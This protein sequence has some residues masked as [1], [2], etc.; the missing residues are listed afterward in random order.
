MSRR[1]VVAGGGVVLGWHKSPAGCQAD[2]KMREPAATNRLAA[3]RPVLTRRRR[4]ADDTPD[5]V[6]HTPAAACFESINRAGR[7]PV[8][9]I[10]PCQSVRSALFIARLF[11]IS[12]SPAHF[13]VESVESAAVVA[14]WSSFERRNR[15]EPPRANRTDSARYVGRVCVVGPGERLQLAVAASSKAAGA[16]RVASQQSQQAAVL[17]AAAETGN[18][19]DGR[20]VQAG[21]SSPHFTRHRPA[22]VEERFWFNVCKLRNLRGTSGNRLLFQT[23]S[24]VCVT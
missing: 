24:S 4:Q 13:R 7:A 10:S 6:S 11:A 12:R 16:Q 20:P 22:D 3:W 14:Q 5:S 23:N 19:S 8:R 2:I 17:A 18:G 21:A 15:G 1:V 9:L